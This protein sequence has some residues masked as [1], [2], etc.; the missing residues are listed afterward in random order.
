M[1]KFPYKL[2]VY[3]TLAALVPTLGPKQRW[4]L[5]IIHFIVTEFD[6]IKI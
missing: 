6:E 3:Q 2:I 5:Q 4:T 1:K